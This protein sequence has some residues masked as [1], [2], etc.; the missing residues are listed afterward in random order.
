VRELFAQVGL[1]ATYVG[2][3][4]HELSGGQAQRV[5]IAR[6]IVGR[7]R[8]LLADEPTGNL[9]SATGASILSLLEELNDEGAT[10]A[11]ITHDH[12]IAARLPRK[13]E[14]LDGRIVSDTEGGRS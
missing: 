4:P 1:D 3:Y 10:I 2:R 7:P 9:D 11:L 5:A 6:A 14:M 13:V 8:I 12:A